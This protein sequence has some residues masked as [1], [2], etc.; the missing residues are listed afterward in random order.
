MLQEQRVA[1]RLDQ[2][3][4]SF[5]ASVADLIPA[6]VVLSTTVFEVVYHADRLGCSRTIL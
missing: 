5:S 6:H 4:P 3:L 2:Q 1:A